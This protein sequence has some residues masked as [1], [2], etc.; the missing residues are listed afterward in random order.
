MGHEK[1]CCLHEIKM[2]G[3]SILLEKRR[4]QQRNHVN[5]KIIVIGLKTMHLIMIQSRN[6]AGIQNRCQSPKPATRPIDEGE[7]LT[8]SASVVTELRS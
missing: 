2:Q 6:L 1:G 5:Y 4:Q 3:C 8:A 7:R